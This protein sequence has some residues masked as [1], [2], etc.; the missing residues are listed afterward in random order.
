VSVGW[1][2]GRPPTT[3]QGTTQGG[4]AMGFYNVAQGDLPYFQSL[5]QTYAISDNHHQFAM[6][7][8]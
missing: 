3:D 2:I 8:R 6:A 7:A 5:A 1:A 4:V